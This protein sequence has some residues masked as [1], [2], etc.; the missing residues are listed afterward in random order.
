MS[1]TAKFNNALTCF[2]TWRAFSNERKIEP[3]IGF[4]DGDLI[5]SFLDLPRSKMEEVASGLQVSVKFC[6]GKLFQTTPGSRRKEDS[7]L[8][9]KNLAWDFFPSWGGVWLA[10]G[11]GFSLGRASTSISWVVLLR[12]GARAGARV[13]SEAGRITDVR[14]GCENKI[15]QPL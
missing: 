1:I 11:A 13:G 5:E 2:S 6:F 3:T 15:Q 14:N 9:V 12:E 4:V 10:R 7:R 8:T